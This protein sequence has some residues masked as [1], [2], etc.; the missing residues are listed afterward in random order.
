MS[1]LS[2]G[3]WN[4]GLMCHVVWLTYD[5]H[6]HTGQLHL[7]DGE[8]CDMT[9]CVALFEGI[10]SE[11]TTISTISGTK[12]DMMYRKVGSV[13]HPLLPSEA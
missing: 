4:Q 2:N 9:G 13:W 12:Q 11:V 5:F 7:L 6:N 1:K 10:D 8:N 3:V